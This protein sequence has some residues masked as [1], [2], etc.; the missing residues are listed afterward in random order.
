M[1]WIAWHTSGGHA[2]LRR[3]LPKHRFPRGWADIIASAAGEAR[4]LLKY[5]KPNE[6]RQPR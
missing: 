4:E 2:G 6:A 1:F 5:A 3:Q